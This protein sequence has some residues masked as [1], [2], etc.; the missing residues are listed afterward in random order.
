MQDI[1][2]KLDETN[3]LFNNMI[4]KY[5][6][7]YVNFNTNSTLSM[8]TS[9]SSSLP[10]NVTVGSGSNSNANIKDPNEELL[11]KYR[12]AA[13][14][15][16]EHTRSQVASNSRDISRIN[17]EITPLQKTYLS[18]LELGD[19]FYN[20]QLAAHATL[21]DYN[22]LYKT[23]FFSILMYLVGSASILYLMFK[24]KLQSV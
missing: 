5:K 8:P 9:S 23:T 22:E 7:N 14:K 17:S 18:T 19:G 10:G 20:T 24:P 16:L 1:Q 15:L 13:N 3:E 21:D 12:F 4:K 2:D 6:M 11:L